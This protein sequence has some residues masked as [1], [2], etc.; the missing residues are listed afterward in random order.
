MYFIELIDVVFLFLDKSP[1]S[2]VSSTIILYSYVERYLDRISNGVRSDDR[3][4]AMTELQS[5]VAESRQAQL[6]F[7]A[8]GLSSFSLSNFL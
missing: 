8:I 5:L 3:R 4:A 1:K 2:F 6:A 7:G